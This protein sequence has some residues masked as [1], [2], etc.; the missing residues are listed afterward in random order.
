MDPNFPIGQKIEPKKLEKFMDDLIDD[1]DE[2]TEEFKDDY[3]AAVKKAAAARLKKLVGDLKGK[4][5]ENKL[6]GEVEE[7]KAEKAK[8]SGD[9]EGEKKHL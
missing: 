9:T 1:C 8:L 6:K 3:D 2:L 7:K 5:E 4:A